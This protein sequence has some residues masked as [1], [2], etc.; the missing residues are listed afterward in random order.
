MRIN[1]LLV[2]LAFSMFISSGVLVAAA[3]SDLPAC[4][5]NQNAHWHNCFGTSTWTSGNEYVGEW[6]DNAKTG[7]GTYTWSN[8][9]NYVG[10]WKDDK[11]AGQ[12]TFTW[13]NG[14]KYVGEWKDDKKTGQG[15][16]TEAEGTVTEVIWK[17]D[18]FVGTIAELERAEKKHIAK[19][20]QDE[21]V[22]QEKKDKYDRIYNACLLD[23]GSNVDMQVNSLEVAVKKTCASIAEK[24]SWLE[25]LRYE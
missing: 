25:T 3:A 6:K 22:R 11:K 13:S 19:E 1:K 9:N 12:G 2:T 16:F 23:K 8:G 10:G 20:K 5:S 18:E 7:Q 17:D 21:L 14:D 15:T 4:P 24:P